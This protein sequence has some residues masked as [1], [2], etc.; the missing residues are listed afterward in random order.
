M[1]SPGPDGKGKGNGIGNRAG[2][3]AAPRLSPALV[4]AVLGLVGL[5]LASLFVGVSDL[6]VG[7]L[8]GT[9][10]STQDL[11]VL[12]VSRVPRTL[13]LVLAGAGM[14][15]AGL[16]M[17]MLARNKFVEPSTAGT[18]ES[19]MLGLLVVMLVAPGLPVFARMLVAAV[20]ALAGTG[21]FLALLRQIPLRSPYVVPLVGIMLG[22]VI[23]S[24]TTFFAYRADM[25]QSLGAWT[26]GD[27]SAILRG[28]YELLWISFAL[29][30]VAYVAADRFTVAGMGEAFSA[31]LG[32]N[33][34]RVA[35][36]G[37][38]IVSLVSATVVVTCGMI[39]FLG[40]IVPNVVSLVM[41]DSLRRSLPWVALGGAGLLLACDIVGR[42]ILAPF[43]LPVGTTM[44]IVGGAGFLALLVRGARHG[45]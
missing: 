8:F 11:E 45:G 43:E 40:L 30:A 28:R 13:A 20:F 2:R 10:G 9:A 3:R 33:H 29:T 32:L 34:R 41:G 31:N 26:M 5:A 38:I 1:P 19:A 15:V 25:M 14:A 36:L 27:F 18:A 16:I 37:L 22:G 23:A 17:Q 39:P 35:M 42:I 44:G 12:L 6:P 7:L 4:L 21:L 24:A